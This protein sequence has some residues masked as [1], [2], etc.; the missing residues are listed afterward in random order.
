M[1]FGKNRNRDGREPSPEQ[2]P[3]ANRTEIPAEDPAQDRP[4]G[5]SDRP[6]IP[7]QD[8]HD[9]P[10]AGVPDNFDFNRYFLAERHVM[11]E[12]VSYETATRPIAAGQ[13]KIGVKDTIVAQ[14]MGQAGVKATYN[15]ALTF[16]PEG[17]FT[18]SV[19]FSVMLVFNPGTRGEVDW[20]T[21]DM[22]AAFRRY[23]P[24]L[25]QAMAAKAALVVA[26]LTNANGMPVI[27]IR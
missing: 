3:D 21:V 22:A 12:N 25:V 11:L 10:V 23:C 15:R 27:P 19:T 20:R 14:V 4:Q 18:L 2:N 1:I 16:D 26:E 5:T 13:Y 17:P 7:A 24:N 6:H 8:S 9:R